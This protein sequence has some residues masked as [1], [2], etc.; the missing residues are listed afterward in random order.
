LPRPD[1]ISPYSWLS[2]WFHPRQTIREAVTNDGD[3]SVLIVASLIGFVRGLQLA[4]AL[5]SGDRLA[6]PLVLLGAAIFGLIAFCLGLAIMSFLSWAIGRWLGGSAAI[7]QVGLALIWAQVP[8]AAEIVLWVPRIGFL[9]RE[10]FASHR[11]YIEA[12]PSLRALEVTCVLLAFVPA[13][14][15]IV[16]IVVCTAE[17]QRF[18]IARA[19]AIS[20]IAWGAMLLLPLATGLPL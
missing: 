3:D 6:L 2:I 12:H 13:I 5:H 9:G 20:V 15:S 14:W 4:T 11:P 1:S 10:A 17:V 8:C 19:V 7:R 18:S 16:L